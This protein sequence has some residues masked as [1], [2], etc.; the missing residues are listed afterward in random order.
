MSARRRASLAVLLVAAF[1]SGILL[2]T[3][4]ANLLNLGENIT[5]ESIAA[6]V[7]RDPV[8]VPEARLELEDAFIQVAETISPAVVQ[9]RSEQIV[10]Q[11]GEPGNPFEGTPFENYFDAPGRQ[12]PQFRSGL[13]SGVIT[14]PNG[15]IITNNHVIAQAEELEVRMADGRFFDAEVIG[16]DPRSD[17]AVIKI[18]SDD[19]PYVSFGTIEDIHIGQFVLAFGSPLSED[20]DNTVTS[21]I[22]SALGRT[23]RSLSNLNLFSAFIQTDAAI[24]PGNSG[25]PLV[26]LRGQLIGLNSAILSRS[27][28]NQGIGFAIP[29]NVVENV[30]TQ[31]IENGRVE[32]AQLGVF[33]DEVSE[34]LAEALGVPRGAAQVSEVVPGSAAEDA[35]LQEGDI[36]TRV[37][38]EG[39]RDFNQLRTMIANMRP[40]EQVDIDFVRDG[41]EHSV[42]VT[43]GTRQ[44]DD[45]VENNQ[46]ERDNRQEDSLED[47]G[48]NL[49]N[50]TPTT[51]RGLGIEDAE[52]L[53]G[54]AITNIDRSSPA[55]RK[56]GLRRGDIITEVDRRKVENLNDFMGIYRE[57]EKGGDFIVRV[58]R[59][60]PDKSLRPFLTA[61]TKPD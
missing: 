10:N 21:G 46:P 22:V 4:G 53:L 50:L 20:L 60:Q 38:G 59:L 24:N 27:G 57:I 58:L 12:G 56:A 29:V 9:I 37:N 55:Y 6:D 2:T 3:A 47:L 40:N 8:R 18:Q 42:T 14:R 41:E 23:S 31:L 54:V 11:E 33:F 34:T 51:L 32:R 52:N 1:L 17:L 44:D 19:L 28:G 30:T 48:L 7:P 26:N 35:G 25:G 5:T 43:L 16:A 36:I 39:L 61:L 13:G 49:R 45:L 15:Y